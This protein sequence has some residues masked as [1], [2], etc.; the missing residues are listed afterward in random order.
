[1]DLVDVFERGTDWSASKISGATSK[2]D[3][4]TTCD[5]W[6][7]RALLNHMIDSQQYFAASARGEEASL[8]SPTPPELIGDDP[9]AAYQHIRQ[10]MLDAYRQPGV[11]E[12]TGP[13][14]G[15]AF[16]DQLVHGWDLAKATGQDATIP[17]DLARAAFAMIDGQ[18][19]DERRGNGFKPAVSV[20]DDASPQERLLAYTGRQP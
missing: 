20:A 7:V 17:D 3:G 4:S 18:L 5:Q 6:D 1:M 16:T 12:K 15:I 2:L 8:P 19:T 11:V 10:E 14:L 13:L 9:V